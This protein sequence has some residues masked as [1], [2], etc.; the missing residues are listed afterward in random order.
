MEV[1]VMFKDKRS[2]HWS[3]RSCISLLVLIVFSLSIFG[4]G[5]SLMPQKSPAPSKENSTGNQSN[6]KQKPPEELETIIT[7]LNSITQALLVQADMTNNPPEQ[8][9]PKTQGGTNQTGQSSQGTSEQGQKADTGTKSNSQGDQ[10][11]DQ[12]SQ[13]NKDSQ[14]QG[15]QTSGDQSKQQDQTGNQ[16]QGQQQSQPS[17]QSQPTPTDPKQQ[18]KTIEQT[19]QELHRNWNSMEPEV[20]KAGARPELIANF[21]TQLTKLTKEVTAQKALP[22][23]IEDNEVYKFIPDFEGLFE[24]KVPPELHRLRYH[25]NAILLKIKAG[26]WPSAKSHLDKLKE[27]WKFLQPRLEEVDTT[28]IS[29]FD[30]SLSDLETVLQKKESQLSE[31]K[32]S[33]V[34]SNLREL[35]SKMGQKQTGQTQGQGQNQGK[36]QSQEQDNKQKQQ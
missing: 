18:W 9:S 34:L 21:E 3:L 28:L 20:I 29:Q 33:I 31:I 10:S 26:D 1:K 17:N 8:V 27:E 5:C 11:K 19:I 15:S 32:A 13:S 23:L 2:S 4:L 7:N 12:S 35:E 24:A 6:Q 25:I 16:Q 30:F 14:N 22:T 36:E